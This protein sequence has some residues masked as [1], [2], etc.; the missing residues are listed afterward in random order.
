[1]QLS[2]YLTY[3]FSTNNLSFRLVNFIHLLTS[4]KESTAL[5]CISF[6]KYNYH[7]T[8]HALFSTFSFQKIGEHFHL[9]TCVL[10]YWSLTKY[11]YTDLDNMSPRLW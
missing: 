8:V 10:L 4:T 11:T 7:I 3:P 9:A 5:D 2:G 1:M 6:F